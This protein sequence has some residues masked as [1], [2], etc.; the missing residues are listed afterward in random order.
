MALVT[1]LNGS[2]MAYDNISSIP[3]WLSDGLSLV[4]TTGGY[5]GRTEQP[6][7]HGVS[8]SAA[9]CVDGNR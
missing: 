2:L 6:G 3:G 5:A 9:G 7:A 8:G 4:A 1:A